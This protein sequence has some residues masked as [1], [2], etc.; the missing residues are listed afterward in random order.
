MEKLRLT[1][2]SCSGTQRDRTHPLC[3]ECNLGA[4]LENQ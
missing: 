3:S 2:E 1:D 4:V